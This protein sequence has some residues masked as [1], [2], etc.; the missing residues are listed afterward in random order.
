M[1][2]IERVVVPTSNLDLIRKAVKYATEYKVLVLVIGE[3]GYGKTEGLKYLQHRY[4]KSIYYRVGVGEPART[5]YARFLSGLMDQ[6]DVNPEFLYQKSYLY[7]LM[8]RA[9]YIIND[10]KDAIDLIIMDEFGNFNRKYI[11]YIRQIW[12]DVNHNTGMV[13]AG[14]PS[15]YQ[16]LLKWRK[17]QV[18]G[19]N[20]L[21][22]RIGSRV[23][24]L[25]DH[26]K[27]DT[28]LICNSREIYGMDEINYFHSQSTDLRMLHSL[29][30]DFQSG[31]LTIE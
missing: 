23:V 12:D 13:L 24:V 5:F 21:L 2:T 28:K 17:Q 7:H 10:K 22:S 11:S 26:N 1:K 20:E 19:I 27:N 16:D 8:D 18:K 15:I 30:D 31:N 6:K 14:P 4:P 29:I 25:E 9:S 3:N